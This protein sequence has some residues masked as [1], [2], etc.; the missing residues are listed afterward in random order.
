MDIKKLKKTYP[1]L[2]EYMETNGFGRVAIDSVNVTFRLL[3]EHEGEYEFYA[4]F[5]SK[6][7]SKEGLSGNNRR[8][9]KPFSR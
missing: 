9:L 5:Y 7:I 6:F 1:N 4:D 8:L 2:L 3:F